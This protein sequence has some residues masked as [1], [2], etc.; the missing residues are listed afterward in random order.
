MEAEK[1]RLK[2][3]LD[4]MRPVLCARWIEER[5]TLPPVLFD[6]LCATVLPERMHPTVDALFWRK[7]AA[8]ES[9]LTAHIPELDDCL[10][11]EMARIRESIDPVGRTE[12]PGWEGIN[13][14][15]RRVI[16]RAWED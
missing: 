5:G 1:V 6:A 8:D 14:L 12:L 9:G 15:F 16:D 4:V 11:R 3:H 7:K 2:K 13:H 10:L